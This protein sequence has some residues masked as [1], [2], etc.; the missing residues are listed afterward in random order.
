MSMCDSGFVV[1]NGVFDVLHAGHYSL[2][3]YAWMQAEYKDSKLIV[4]IDSDERVRRN[5][6]SNLVNMIV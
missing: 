5:K 6:L 2:I 4:G 1:V 3:N